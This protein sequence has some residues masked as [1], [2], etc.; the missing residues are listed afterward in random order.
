[1]LQTDGDAKYAAEIARVVTT[2]TMRV[3]SPDHCFEP[4]GAE[5][6]N[7]GQYETFHVLEIFPPVRMAVLFLSLHAVFLCLIIGILLA[8]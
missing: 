5:M 8:L 6:D 4:R 7:P 1:M 2:Y 3:K